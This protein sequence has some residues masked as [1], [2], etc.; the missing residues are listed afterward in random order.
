MT[1]DIHSVHA[2]MKGPV[3]E[4][5]LAP[6]S[7]YRSL[8]RAVVPVPQNVSVAS[9]VVHVVLKVRM[10]ASGMLVVHAIISIVNVIQT[11]AVVVG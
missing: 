5:R 9:E 1:N 8:A 10:S 11:S 3:R 7:N 4:I 6:V 2:L